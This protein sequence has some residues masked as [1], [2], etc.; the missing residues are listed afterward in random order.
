ME[1]RLLFAVV[2]CWKGDESL[3]GRLGGAGS[4]WFVGKRVI[5]KEPLKALL[6]HRGDMGHEVLTSGVQFCRPERPGITLSS[7]VLG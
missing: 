1:G 2:W 3:C 6:D 5:F 7:F 4:Y